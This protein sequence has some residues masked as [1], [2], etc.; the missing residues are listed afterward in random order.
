MLCD[1]LAGPASREGH[2]TGRADRPR[3]CL[4]G[5]DLVHPE[6]KVSP[7]GLARAMG[8]SPG[9]V[10]RSLGGG[11]AVRVVAL[12]DYQGLVAEYSAGRAGPDGARMDRYP[13]ASDRR[14]PGRRAARRRCG[15]GHAR[16]DPVRPRAARAGCLTSSCWSPPGR[17]TPRST[18]PAAAEHGVTVSGTGGPRSA[19]TAELTWALILV[20]GPPPARGDGRG[21][22][23][24]LA[25]HRRHRPAR[26]HPRP[27][28]AGPHRQPDGPASGRPSR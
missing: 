25:A 2:V 9:R 19:N 14:R 23:R 24:R 3:P 5:R 20:A 10:S 17:P 27:G 4:R 16:A 18:W 12:D 1:L 22:A 7:A 8:V 21:A 26:R 6:H 15:R 28:R 11:M 13:R